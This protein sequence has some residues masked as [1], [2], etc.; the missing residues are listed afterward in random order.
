MR[1]SDWSSDVCSSDLRHV[2]DSAQ[3]LDWAD[4]DGSW[5]DVGAGAGFPGMLVALL[6]DRPVALCEP[7]K[8]RAAFLE[9]AAAALDIADRVTIAATKVQAVSGRFAVI[10]ARAVAALPD[11]FAAACHN[12]GRDTVWVVPKGRRAREEEI[13]RAHV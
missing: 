5:L 9:R 13:G 6:S 2:V 1:I 11:L 10:S 8:R 12:A 3:L 4:R 7:R